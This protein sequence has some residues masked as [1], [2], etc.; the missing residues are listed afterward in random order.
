[1]AN[2][3]FDDYQDA[4]PHAEGLAAY[5]DGDRTGAVSLLTSVP[6]TDPHYAQAMETARAIQSEIAHGEPAKVDPFASYKDVDPFADYQDIS[7]PNR[8]VSSAKQ[9]VKEFLN[10]APAAA[11]K[12]SK[13]IGDFVP[14]LPKSPTDL[15][16]DPLAPVRQIETG[17]EL[18]APVVTSAAQ[19]LRDWAGLPQSVYQKATGTPAEDTYLGRR[20]AEHPIELGL[21]YLLPLA[22][23]AVGAIKGVGAVGTEIPALSKMAVGENASQVLKNFPG[24][25]TTEGQVAKEIASD[26]TQ[27]PEI[28]GARR[29]AQL[30]GQELKGGVEAVRNKGIVDDLYDFIGRANSLREEIMAAP[31]NRSVE[32]TKILTDG[33]DSLQKRLSLP[34]G[35]KLDEV[36]LKNG[37]AKRI[38]E[39]LANDQGGVSEP[40]KQLDEVMR[41]RLELTPDETGGADV[42]QGSKVFQAHRA[43]TGATPTPAILNPSDLTGSAWNAVKAAFRNTGGVM[44]KQLL[45]V[46]DDPA[47]LSKLTKAAAALG[48]PAGAMSRVGEPSAI[49]ASVVPTNTQNWLTAPTIQAWTMAHHLLF[50]NDPAY[51]K[52]AQ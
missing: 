19:G 47:A 6:K 18:A 29:G 45:K 11:A 35:D 15:I 1:M 43:M 14:G 46:G 39:A 8:I 25:V 40:L 10:Q 49:P 7:Y 26:L 50:Q 3:S 4:D 16:P 44:A 17:A 34:K 42:Q 48:A 32:D 9:G 41:R 37:E 22:E 2:D 21:N 24:A 5:S 52:A 12:V 51:R 27:N 23:G 33:I 20:L 38:A 31:G 28:V 13:A 30:S 36:V